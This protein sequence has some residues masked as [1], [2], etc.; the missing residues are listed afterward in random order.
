MR[1]A[2]QKSWISFLMLAALVLLSTAAMADSVN[3]SGSLNLSSDGQGNI[4]F[5]FGNAAVTGAT[6]W[7]DR[8]NDFSGV[9]FLLGSDIV[10]HQGVNTF[11]PSVTTVQIGT[12]AND[13]IGLFTGTIEF[14]TISG[15]DGNFNID[16]KLNS[17]QY[18][19]IGAADEQHCV[20]ASGV[21]SNLAVNQSGYLNFGFTFAGDGTHDVNELTQLGAGVYSSDGF[22]GTLG[23]EQQPFFSRTESAT[24]PEPATFALVGSGLLA[25]ANFVRRKFIA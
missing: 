16:I 24:V 14:I 15:F 8:L 3:F 20:G 13:G 1:N 23:T 18:R 4:G 7:D 5:N 22:D 2:G 9:P 17:I 6:P 19:C 25:G 11:S 12:A 21:L 10:L